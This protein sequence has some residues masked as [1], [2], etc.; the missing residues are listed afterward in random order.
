M[1]EVDDDKT[2]VVAAT[3]QAFVPPLFV[4]KFIAPVFVCNNKVFADEVLLISKL[5]PT[6]KIPE[7]WYVVVET[8]L[9]NLRRKELISEISLVTVLVIIEDW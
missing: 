1:F 6:G 8:G 2:P 7:R 4:F 5:S 3:D 9:W